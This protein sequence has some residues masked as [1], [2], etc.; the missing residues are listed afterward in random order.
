MKNFPERINIASYRC[1][2]KAN[3]DKFSELNTGGIVGGLSSLRKNHRI[4]WFCFDSEESVDE[5]TNMTI[6]RISIDRE[7][8]K[9]YYGEFCNNYLWPIFHYLRKADI[10]RVEP[11]LSYRESNIKMVNKISNEI[12]SRESILVNDYHLSLVPEELN[13]KG[14]EKISFFWHI[15]WVSPEYLQMFPWIKEIVSGIS[16]AQKIGFHLPSYKNNFLETSRGMISQ[17]YS[18]QTL[19]RRVV[20]IPL[21]IDYSEYEN[22]EIRKNK[23]DEELKRI[24]LKGIKIISSLSRLDYTKGILQKL[25][26]FRHFLINNPK[27]NGKVVL[28]LVVSPSR[29]EVNEYKW[30]KESIDKLVGN[31]NSMLRTPEW[32]P[33]IYIYRKISQ[34]E[35]FSLYR[36][37]DAF[38]V[39]PIMDG[40][41]LV[42]EEYISSN[43]NGLLILSKFAGISHYI[44]ATEKV[45][46][47]N[48]EE[49][50]TAIRN[51]LEISDEIKVD[52][53]SKMREF[54]RKYDINNWINGMILKGS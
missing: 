10:F 8:N 52:R 29:E 22:V 15:P 25:E 50:S 17:K 21:G 47:F 27:F 36:N 12:E 5:I 3:K 45:N 31:M 4:N 7:K 37:S 11:W 54:I 38:L 1:P 18:Y 34:S 23:F 51:I 13:G 6:H 35:V 32:T 28:V 48:L 53:A 2:F 41:N 26:A 20:A 33:V 9:L 40:L 24:K 19:E 39:T 30:Y 49:F 14:F 43:R 46:P 16:G 42:A 44:E